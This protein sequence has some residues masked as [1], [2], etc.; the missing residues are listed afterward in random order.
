MLSIFY[1]LSYSQIPTDGLVAYYPFNSNAIDESNNGNDGTI[2]GPTLTNDRFGNVNSAYSFNGGN[3][4]IDFGHNSSQSFTNELTVISWISLDHLGSDGFIFSKWD[5]SGYNESFYLA[6]G[7]MG[8]PYGKIKF[9]DNQEIT[10]SSLSALS[11]RGWH[12]ITMIYNGDSATLMVDSIVVDNVYD[13]RQ[14]L[15]GTSPLEANK[16][17]FIGKIDDCLLYN[18]ALSSSEIDGL[19]HE[20][21]WTTY[22]QF[23][24]VPDDEFERAV[25]NFID[26]YVLTSA[27]DTVRNL[28]LSFRSVSNITGVENFSNLEFLDIS[29]TLLTSS[30]DLSGNTKLKEFICIDTNIDSV[31][32]ANCS[33]LE[34]LQFICNLTSLDVSNSPKLTYLKCYGGWFETLDLSNNPNIDTLD[35]YSIQF[36]SIT[37][38]DSFNINYIHCNQSMLDSLIIPQNNSLTYLDC[39]QGS[40]D[41]LDL[42]GCSALIELDCSQNGMLYLDVTTNLSLE[43]LYCYSNGF[44]NID[45]S[46]NTALTH[47]D[48]YANFIG[49][50][51]LSNNTSLQYLQV[52]E[53]Q[54]TSLDVSNNPVLVELQCWNNWQLSSL[55]VKNG[56]NT[57]FTIFDARNNGN[58]TCIQVDD[59]AWSNANWPNKDVTASYSVKCNNL[60]PIAGCQDIIVS[61]NENCETIVTPPEVDNNSFDPDGDPIFLSLD[62]VGPYPLGETTVTL[63]V[64]DD[65]GES[66]QCTATITVVDD[67]PPGIITITDPITLWPPNHNYASFNIND[68]VLSVSDNCSMLNIDDVLISRVASDEPENANGGGDG[69]T[70]DDIVIGDDCKSVLLRKERS[71]NG[72]GRVYTIYLELDDN[73]G[74]TSIANCQ[75]HVP[76]N[77]NGTAIDDGMAYEEIGDCSNKSSY[78]TTDD[79]DIINFTVYP[80][81]IKGLATIAFTTP[82][83]KSTTLKV[84]NSQGI[85]VVS[86]YSGM[87][88]AGQEYTFTF[89]GVVHKNGVYMIHLQYGK[90][91]NLTKK[92]LLIN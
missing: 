59:A 8:I 11:D 55:N 47:L 20:G 45:V 70:I 29:N 35:F 50:I 42:S 46:S 13:T 80:N 74:N 32:L 79:N 21:G 58:L 43:K 49:N 69:N 4:T 36:H 82:E 9:N 2:W 52:Q 30:V 1:L 83:S 88:K 86:L 24:Y 53:G 18:R 28:N 89:K 66:D 48:A 65:S 72:N 33:D 27:I 77:N 54:M 12:M 85:E 31:N 39:S 14:I 25:D 81:P 38:S 44:E 10:L 5:E 62:P 22:S 61:A 87:V 7:P 37:F 78:I 15:S 60:P 56:N 3:N 84:Y 90:D 76:H 67:T 57:N 41:S 73:N 34:R 91:I 64:T 63:T 75:V 68:F 40:I 51:D 19:Y 71:A 16:R 26:D 17:Y 6:L 23:T 92:V